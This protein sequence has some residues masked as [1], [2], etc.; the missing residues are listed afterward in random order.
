MCRSELH[1]ALTSVGAHNNHCTTAR[2]DAI[3]GEGVA[4]AGIVAIIIHKDIV[5]ILRDTSLSKLVSL[6]QRTRLTL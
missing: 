4:V 2:I 3:K 6:P 5:E 1:E